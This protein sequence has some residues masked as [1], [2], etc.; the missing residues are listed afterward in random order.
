MNANPWTYTLALL[1]G[2]VSCADRS[3]PAGKESTTARR[4]D[5]VMVALDN[6]RWDHTSLAGYERSTTPM[7][8]ALS[9]LPGSVTFTRAWTAASWS[10]PAY[11]SIFTGKHGVHHGAGFRHVSLPEE[12]WTLAEVL[13]TYGYETAA[14]VGGLHLNPEKG[15]DQGFDL[16]S[17]SVEA[18]TLC[19]HVQDAIQWID[20]RKDKNKPFFLFVHGYD[21]H[22]PLTAVPLFEEIYDPGYTGVLHAPDTL[23]EGPGL[24]KDSGFS[25][26]RSNRLIMSPPHMEQPAVSLQEKD[27]HHLRAHYDSAVRFAD[28]QLGRLLSAL[29]ERGLLKSSLVLALADHGEDLGERS[30]FQH[31][32]TL[33][34]YTLHVPLV[35]RFPSEAPPVVW[36]EMFSFVDL[37]PGILTLLDIPIPS[38]V[39]GK[40][41]FRLQRDGV[42]FT[43]WDSSAVPEKRS[44]RA[45]SRLGFAIR[46]EE[47]LYTRELKMGERTPT[48]ALFAEGRPP[49][50]LG[51]N[52]EV[53]GLLES[54]LSDWPAVPANRPPGPNRESPALRE[55]LK[56]AGYWEAQPRSKNT[57]HRPGG[58]K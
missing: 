21:A 50:V 19:G 52:P 29:D 54:E 9:R 41:R 15:L 33:A 23:I 53:V 7:W 57:G 5:I 6:V 55:A 34:D 51:D 35:V 48:R 58:G 38:G 43:P 17:S 22:S 3:M 27:Y 11:A 26:L 44:I 30:W 16:Y 32:A 37:M 25:F 8:E 1:A 2:L 46:T 39:D 31:D 18:T 49:D 56:D 40:N 47:W 36:P 28:L 45:A 14:F 10:Q 20:S 42:G 24:P 12:H 13:K 4:P